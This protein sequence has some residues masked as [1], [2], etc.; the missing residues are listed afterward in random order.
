MTNLQYRTI[1]SIPNASHPNIKQNPPKGASC[2]Y[3]F[4]SSISATV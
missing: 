2:P 4:L 3:G 1:H